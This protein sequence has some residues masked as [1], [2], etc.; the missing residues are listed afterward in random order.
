MRDSCHIAGAA[1]RCNVVQVVPENRRRNSQF[2]GMCIARR[3]RG[4]GSS[5]T[6]RNVVDDAAVERVFPLCAALR[7]PA[8]HRASCNSARQPNVKP[9]RVLRDEQAMRVNP[10]SDDAVSPVQSTC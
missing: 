6:L 1:N 5:F 10:Y 8:A 4:L 7:S 3:N 9:A 2:R